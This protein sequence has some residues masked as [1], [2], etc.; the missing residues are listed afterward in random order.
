LAGWSP[1][2]GWFF[3]QLY[4]SREHA[5]PFFLLKI[6]AFPDEFFIYSTIFSMVCPEKRSI[7]PFTRPPMANQTIEAAW[8]N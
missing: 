4:Q 2:T 7:I 3:C 5:A 8:T 6:F 1:I